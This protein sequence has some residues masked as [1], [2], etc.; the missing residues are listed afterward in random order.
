M[1]SQTFSEMCEE[2]AVRLYLKQSGLD[3]D[4]I[5]D[6][7]EHHGIKGM[8]WGQRRWQHDDG[9][10]TAAGREHYG[11]GDGLKKRQ[12]KAN[13][14]A[15][16]DG[17]SRPAKIV[18]PNRREAKKLIKTADAQM[19]ARMDYYDSRKLSSI[20]S[21]SR[22]QRLTDKLG[23]S[24][25]MRDVLARSEPQRANLAAAETVEKQKLD[26]F[27]KD[28]KLYSKFQN[29]ALQ[30][31]L[32]G[33]REDLE[34]DGYE[35]SSIKDILSQYERNF[36]YGDGDQGATYEKWLDSGHP[37]A[38]AYAEAVNATQ[39]ARK[40]YR[41]TLKSY[42]SEFT[43]EFGTQPI[44]NRNGSDA[45]SYLAEFIQRYDSWGKD[46]RYIGSI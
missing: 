41:E 20:G 37:T 22:L 5:E 7:L 8:K 44:N 21:K 40:E 46:K 38:K 17:D 33:I 12:D 34:A 15:D 18:G 25:Q 31:N 43:G 4:A 28:K 42:I 1:S 3:D 11:V 13:S 45:N 2:S 36:R 23:N 14:A 30:E 26:A 24:P 29:E 9:S 16:F 32:K 27:Y 10:L 39:A 19:R 35:E 6:Y